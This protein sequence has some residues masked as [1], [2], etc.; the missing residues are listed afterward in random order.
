MLSRRS[1][2]FLALGLF[3]GSLLPAASASRA[4]E[5]ESL[6]AGLGKGTLY[7]IGGAAD[8]AL[9]RFAELAGKNAKIVILPHSSSDPSGSGEELCNSFRALGVK[10]T[11]VLLPAEKRPIPDCSAIFMSGGDQS[12]M[13]RLLPAEYIQDMKT[14]LHSGLLIGGS[15]AGAAIMSS[16]MISGGMSDGLPRGDSL[17]IT[18]GLGLLPGYLIDTHV[19]K[20]SRQ[21]R[22]MAALALVPGARGIGLDEDTAVEISQNQARVYGLALAHVYR[23]SDSFKSKLLSVEAGRPASVEDVIYSVFPAGDSFS[24]F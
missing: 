1:F 18:D 9:R 5:K 22:L 19:S 2:S 6:L 23:R 17:T 10:E 4:E 3:S 14:R 13:M 15:S 20:R 21:E 24:L 7:P 8:F 11:D 16:P 12:R